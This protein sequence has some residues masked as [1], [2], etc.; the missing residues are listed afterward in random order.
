MKARKVVYILGNVCELFTIVHL[1]IDLYSI[2]SMYLLIK[3][4][5]HSNRI[6][7]KKYK[8]TYECGRGRTLALLIHNETKI[9]QNKMENNWTATVARTETTAEA[10]AAATNQP[11]KQHSH[12]QFFVRSINCYYGIYLS[13]L[14]P[15]YVRLLYC[16][17]S[18]LIICQLI[19]HIHTSTNIY[20]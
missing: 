20:I 2:R 8:I 4:I 17:L 13:K 1:P 16:D 12:T 6:G 11:T 10:A 5:G 3:A 18:K 7:N 9:I 15:L 14:N 19:W